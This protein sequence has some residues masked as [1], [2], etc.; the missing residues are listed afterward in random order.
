MAVK[1]ID[2]VTVVDYTDA[3]NV[4]TWYILVSRTSSAPVVSP[5]ATEAQMRANGW[6][7]V[8]PSV[9]TTKK[10]YT[11]QQC[12]F[13]DSTY[14]WGDVSLSSSY[15]AAIQAYNEA[16]IAKTTATNY[17]T[18]IAGG[19]VYVHK[20][21]SSWSSAT[22][23]AVRIT[24]NSVDILKNGKNVASFGANGTTI[25]EN[26]NDKT[27][28]EI[29]NNGLRV[30]CKKYDGSEYEII[31]F[32]HG[33]G[34]TS[35]GTSQDSPYMLFGTM[36]VN[37]D[38][39]DSSATYSVGDICIYNDD[40]YICEN[41]IT[42]P[43]VWTPNHWCHLWGYNAISVGDNAIAAGY[44]S[45]SMG[46]NTKAIASHS[47]AEGEDCLAAD[48][49]THAEGLRAIATG[50]ASHTEGLETT[51]SGSYSH[52]EGSDTISS[53]TGSHSEGWHTAA[54][55]SGSHA[56]GIGCEVLLMANDAHAQNY[57][58]IA[59]KAASTVLGT[60]NEIDEYEGTIHPSGFERYGKYAIILGNGSDE[61]TRSNALTVDWNGNVDITGSYKIN[62]NALSASNVGAVPTTRTINGIALS[63]DVTLDSSDVG[64]VPTTRTVNGKALSSNISLTASDVSAVPTTRKINGKALSSDVTL[65]ITDFDTVQTI[66]TNVTTTT[67]TYVTSIC[68]RYGQLVQLTVGIRNASAVAS[69]GD[70]YVGTFNS[71]LPSPI[72]VTTTGSFFGKT[73]VTAALNTS[74]VLTVRNSSPSSVTI[75]S[76]STVYVSFTYLTTA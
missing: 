33:I 52:A 35:S 67:G 63:S 28:T 69:G 58:T 3:T 9:D 25:G 49:Y 57:Y 70:F 72:M 76:S 30:I 8:E 1:S 41:N 26:A 20:D 19:G 40:I 31:H 29:S 11:V 22:G 45:F 47:H 4:K 14:V 42:T 56:E 2:S 39:Y 74:R 50:F 27:R 71:A 5:T 54:R 59:A 51:A 61:N 55:G 48:M 36:S 38:A 13:G 44:A 34:N 12:L 18:D 46:T 65:E 75:G 21:D 24:D 32:G 15:E 66:N 68:R 16:Q 60:F 7:T 17:M 23:D 53:N 37:A 64:A 6:G 10:L 73:P 62:G 43:E